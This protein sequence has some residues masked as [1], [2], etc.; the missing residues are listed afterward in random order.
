MWIE[1]K[2]DLPDWILPFVD[3]HCG[4][5]QT[6]GF[7]KAAESELNDHSW[8]FVYIE[9][10]TESVFLTRE[11]AEAFGKAREYR[12]DK[13]K[14]YCVPC[15]GELAAI[16]KNYEPEVSP[17]WEFGKASSNGRPVPTC[18]KCGWAINGDLDEHEVKCWQPAQMVG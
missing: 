5:D 3:A 8:P 17:H 15:D 10:K 18:S 14:V 6:D 13:W 1:E 4:I 11:E 7:W 2:D 16:L 9:W 12:W